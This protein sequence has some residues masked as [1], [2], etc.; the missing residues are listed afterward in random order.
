[1]TVNVRKDCLEEWDRLKMKK[2]SRYI[3][4][5]I[6]KSEEVFVEKVGNRDATWE[7]FIGTMPADDMRYAVFDFEFTNKDGM[8]INKLIFVSWGPDSA[9]GRRKTIFASGK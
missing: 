3:I 9:K 8:C 6:D 5:D 2:E 1:M 7:E 4:F